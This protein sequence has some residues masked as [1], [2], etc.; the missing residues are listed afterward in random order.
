M[1]Q[2][3]SG[4]HVLDA[5]LAFLRVF[6]FQ[7]CALSSTSSAAFSWIHGPPL[8]DAAV[9]PPSAPPLEF[10]DDVI[11]A[12]AEA[13]AA[14]KKWCESVSF[15]ADIDVRRLRLRPMLVVREE[16]VCVGLFLLL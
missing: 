8:F 3:Y 5:S 6:D 15:L 16:E 12:S 7:R 14:A 1:W 11:A 2:A 4:E 10:S 9:T 13:A